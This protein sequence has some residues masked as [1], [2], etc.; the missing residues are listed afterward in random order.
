[1]AA[2]KYSFI[3]YAALFVAV[4]ATW[5]VYRVIGST[6]A[7]AQ[8]ATRPVVVASRNINDG[9]AI[10]DADI[11]VEQW[12]APVIPDSSFE[13]VAVVAGRVARVAV[14]MGEAI[15]PGRLA[16]AGT[17]PGLEAKITPGKR[18]MSVRVDDVSGINGLIQPNSRVDILLTLAGGGNDQRTAKLFM[19][20]MRVLAMGHDV[21]RDADGRPIPTSVATLEVT[22]EESERLAVADA[23]GRIR[24]VLRGYS[25]PD[26]T[27]TRG[28]T[29]A[30]VVASLRDFVPAARPPARRPTTPSR[31]QPKVE[32]EPQPAAPPPPVQAPPQKPESLNVEIFRGTKRSVEKFSK[33]S[34]K[35][36]TS[37]HRN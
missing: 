25:D 7:Q 21:Q 18:A 17:A 4:L 2:K 31:A 3:L 10:S 6:K 8:I 26:S 33:D 20:N 11:H 15:V 13:S 30:E 35:P 14:F 16:P 19:P 29:T 32:P 24:L 37:F 36:D 12:P 5:G 22:P 28:A 27:K 23:Q 1:M 9:E 34:I